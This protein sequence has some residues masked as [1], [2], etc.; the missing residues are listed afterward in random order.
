V[1]VRFSANKIPLK[2]C[3]ENN[4]IFL[5]LNIFLRG[6]EGGVGQGIKK[7]SPKFFFP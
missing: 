4:A 5:V 3:G 2:L 7:K 1:F 6:E